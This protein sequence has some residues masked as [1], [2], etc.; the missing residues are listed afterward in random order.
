VGAPDLAVF[1]L[2]GTLTRRDTMLPFLV[3][4][5]GRRRVTTSLVRTAPAMARAALDRA[6]RDDAKEQLIALTLAG[7]GAADVDA[8]GVAYAAHVAETQLR[9]DMVARLR[10]HQAEGHE[11]A[12]ASAS[13]EAYVVPLA[14]HLGVGEVVATRLEVG[15]DGVLT[16]RL[17]GANCRGQEKLR[18]LAELFGSRPIAWAYGDSVDDQAML[19]RAAHPLVVGRAP[20]SAVGTS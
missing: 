4:L 5:G 13:V 2:D 14:R 1:D 17:R 16:G 10:W 20:V 3:R 6:R 7:R 12:I 15:A 8:A 11:C 19:D 9:P 18:R